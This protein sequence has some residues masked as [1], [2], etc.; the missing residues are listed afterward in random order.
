[1]P[2][3]CRHIE[4]YEEVDITISKYPFFLR[5]RSCC[6]KVSLV[7]CHL[8]TLWQVHRDSREKLQSKK[9]SAFIICCTYHVMCRKYRLSARP[10]L[11]LSLKKLFKDSLYRFLHN[12]L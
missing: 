10:K 6:A 11:G 7:L 4:E 2:R 3:G 5:Q 9:K 8:K 1:M 12:Y